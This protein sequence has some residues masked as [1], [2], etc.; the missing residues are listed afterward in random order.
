MKTLRVVRGLQLRLKLFD[1]N[2][3]LTRSRETKMNEDFLAS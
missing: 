2:E 1:I 3:R